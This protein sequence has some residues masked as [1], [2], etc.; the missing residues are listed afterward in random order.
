M[1]NFRG[2]LRGPGRPVTR[3]GSREISSMLS[4]W[5]T[6]V[7]TKLVK[8]DDK[9]FAIVT[10]ECKGSHPVRVFEEEID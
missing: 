4:T 2:S 3:L 10:I 7:T 8:D 1:A 6:H 5:H 9:I